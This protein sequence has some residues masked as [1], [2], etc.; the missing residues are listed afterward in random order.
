MEAA[1]RHR[2]KYR[3][4]PRERARGRNKAGNG[5]ERGRHGPMRDAGVVVGLGVHR[6]RC[7][8]G[9]RWSPRAS[10]HGF[11][12]TCTHRWRRGR[13]RRGNARLPSHPHKPA[14]LMRRRCHV[15]LLAHS[16][17]TPLS[18]G[19]RA[20]SSS[21]AHT[22]GEVC[23]RQAAECMRALVRIANRRAQAASKL[24]FSRARSLPSTCCKM[25]HI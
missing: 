25:Q 13:R 9:V 22:G 14:H 15:G 20:R 11:G 4:V 18:K 21:T 12:Q 2:C 6:L 7:R 19:C 8:L 16:M 1:G 10:T 23:G 3:C 17:R 5:G 24:P